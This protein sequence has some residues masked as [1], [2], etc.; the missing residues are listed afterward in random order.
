MN[1]NSRPITW[2]VIPPSRWSTTR[3]LTAAGAIYLPAAF[4]GHNVDFVL[5]WLTR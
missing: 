5:G 3:G 4:G 1:L 2:I